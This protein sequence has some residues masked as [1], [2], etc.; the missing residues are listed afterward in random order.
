MRAARGHRTNTVWIA[1]SA[2]SFSCLCEQ[3]L[4]S[5]RCAGASFL[6]A[7]R[8]A[9]VKGTLDS[10]SDVGFAR[11]SSGHELIVRRVDRPPSLARRDAR[12]LE[13]V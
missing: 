11:C 8:I 13:L 6:E 1:P 4:G 2:T 10:E 9:N 3:C 7:V 12:Q 5:I